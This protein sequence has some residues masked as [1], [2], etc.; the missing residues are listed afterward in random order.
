MT[1]IRERVIEV[2]GY[3]TFLEKIVTQCGEEG[4]K[5]LD[6]L[7]SIEVSFADG[8]CFQRL[9]QPRELSEQLLNA[10]EVTLSAVLPSKRI[11]VATKK[12]LLS[13]RK[14]KQLQTD[15]NEISSD[16]KGNLR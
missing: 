12:K 10:A 8:S 3:D 1:R 16:L 13:R 15:N 5:E 11:V 4:L 14:I 2:Q 9:P 7:C 6:A